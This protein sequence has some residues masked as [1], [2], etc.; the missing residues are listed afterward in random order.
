M[1]IEQ[2]KNIIKYGDSGYVVTLP[3]AWLRYYKLDDKDKI[4]LIANGK[5]TIEPIFRKKSK[6]EKETKK[7]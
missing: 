3:K 6:Q 7:E 5:I 2:I 4:R 1:P